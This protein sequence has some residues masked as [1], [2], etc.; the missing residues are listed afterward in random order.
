MDQDSFRFLRP[1]TQL[2]PAGG[3]AVVTVIGSGGCTTL[4]LRLIEVCRARGVRTLVAHTVARPVPFACADFRCP[5]DADAVRAALD[6]DGVAYVAG[7]GTEAAAAVE[8]VALERIAEAAAADVVLVES[9]HPNGGRLR[10]TADAPVWPRRPSL[11]VVVGRIALVGAP[12][13]AVNVDGADEA[14][15]VDGEVVRVTTDDVVA[16][17]DAAM[18]TVPAGVRVLPFLTGFGAF[19]DLDGM[20]AA[21]E[22]LLDPPQRPVLC[23][24]ELLGDER[25]DGADRRGIDEAHASP[26]LDDERVYAVYPAALDDD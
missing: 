23:F 21:V 11:A 3:A 19:R 5:P 18:R 1:W 20:F 17:L 12:W 14:E 4:L 22:R 26:W 10:T 13:S 6:A 15:I 7:E 16:A 25:R 8:P 2:L 9:S 24:G